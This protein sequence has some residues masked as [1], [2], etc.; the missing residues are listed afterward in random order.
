[1]KSET[2]LKDGLTLK[3]Y[4]LNIISNISYITCQTKTKNQTQYNE[5]TKYVF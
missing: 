5:T 3:T 4:S 1:M 2:D